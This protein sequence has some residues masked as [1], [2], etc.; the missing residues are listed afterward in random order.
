M[1]CCLFITRV[2]A[3]G[4]DGDDAVWDVDSWRPKNEPGGGGSESATGMDRK[5]YVVDDCRLNDQSGR[6]AV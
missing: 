5:H 1:W 4:T 3:T 2:S 6:V